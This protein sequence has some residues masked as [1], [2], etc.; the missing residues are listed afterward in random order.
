MFCSDLS[1]SIY[2]IVLGTTL[3]VIRPDLGSLDGPNRQ[4]IWIEIGFK[5]WPTQCCLPMDREQTNLICLT[6]RLGDH[7]NRTTTIR[8]LTVDMV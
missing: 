1:V 5:I 3:S 8:N 6:I 4:F 7:N 2:V